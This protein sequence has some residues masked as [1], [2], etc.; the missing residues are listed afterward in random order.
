MLKH[1]TSFKT[2]ST[3]SLLARAHSKTP[4]VARYCLDVLT[5]NIA[6]GRLVFLAVERHVRDLTEGEARGLRYDD[7]AAA[8]V[9]EF[10]STFLYVAHGDDRSAFI[11][12]PWQQFILAC[13]FGWKGP[14]GFR[15]YRTAYLE[16]GKGNGKSP[17]AAGIGI[18]GLLADGE[19]EA[20]IYAAAV[21]KDQA[22]I[23]FR[24]AENMRSFSPLLRQKIAAHVNNLSVRSTASFFRPISS[25]KKGLDGKRVHMALLDEIHEHPSPLVV[26]KMRAGTK[27]RRQALI[28]MITNSG[29]DPESVCWNQHEFSR[30]I[31]EGLVESDGHFSY[32]CHLDACEECQSEGYVQPK[33]GCATCDSWLDEDVWRKANPNLGVSIRVEYLRELVTEAVAM[34]TKQGIVMRLNFC[35]WTQG[36]NRAIGAQAWR[37]CAGEGADDP[38]AWRA[39]KIEQRKGRRCF[40]GFDLGCTDDLTCWLEFFPK[41]SGIDKAFVLPF[42]YAPRESV[43]LRTQRD[44]IPYDL[45]EKSGFLTVTEGQTTDYQFIREDI[46]RCA[47]VS[48]VMEIRYDR[49][50]ALDTVNQLLADGLKLVDH[51]MGISMHDPTTMVLTAVK[52]KS[53]E[54]GNNP[55]LAFCA[56]NLVTISDAKGNIN[57]KKP[58]N[59][60]SPKKIDGMVAF[61]LAKAAAA[62]N[63]VPTS[64]PRLRT[65]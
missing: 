22:K 39:R 38:V 7:D 63:P 49:Y 6:V 60:N 43:A 14:D 26:D 48:E 61:A 54:H 62:A 12:E 29:F 17:L 32:I 46:K 37:A 16:I 21:M 53:F 35:F 42:F 34:P 23:L 11:P 10:F 55:V 5:G 41:Q 52:D 18:F 47:A 64:R 2:S 15:R 57:M 59:P 3:E 40:G 56:D 65:L 58:G 51:P 50:K 25:E 31:L 30:K 8:Y 1:K 27:G 33:D 24:D 13:L 20:E 19:D 9:I 45:W 28:F 44:R 4:R 36:E